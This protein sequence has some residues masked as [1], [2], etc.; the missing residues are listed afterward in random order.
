M[1]SR[2]TLHPEILN[3]ETKGIDYLHPRFGL[4]SRSS[5]KRGQRVLKERR[6][7]LKSIEA[8]YGVPR[9]V[10]IAIFRVETNLGK[11]LGKYRVF[12]SLLTLTVMVN[13]RSVWAGQEL[14][15]LFTL[16]K[17]NRTNPF[18]IRGSAAGA[19]GLCQFVPSSYLAYGVDGNDD[20]VVDLFDFPDAMAST[21]NYLKSHGW[22]NRNARKQFQAIWAYNRCENYV[23]AVLAYSRQVKLRSS[24]KSTTAQKK[25]DDPKR[26]R[27]RGSN[28]TRIAEDRQ[29]QR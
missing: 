16:C 19:F 7:I 25:Y 11:N 29:N 21:A 23:K 6:N 17:N 26:I 22:H 13:R 15:D 18:S 5:I 28:R 27:T 10:L 9:E 20:G 1:D 3:Q 8:S 14:I 24:L 2:L 4:L 12:N